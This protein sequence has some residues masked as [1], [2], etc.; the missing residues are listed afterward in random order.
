MNVWF[1]SEDDHVWLRHLLCNFRRS[2]EITDVG[3]HHIDQMTPQWPSFVFFLGSLIGLRLNVA[4]FW[5]GYTTYDFGHLTI[6]GNKDHW[7]QA[8]F[9]VRVT[10]ILSGM[11]Y[12]ANVRSRYPRNM[13]WV[14][15]HINFNSVL[16]PSSKR[17]PPHSVWGGGGK[18]PSHTWWTASTIPE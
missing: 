5:H 17:R 4:N 18:S 10:S 8:I 16:V 15:F 1:K 6:S 12:V 7:P 2:F 14:L 13:P 3:W 9:P 11:L